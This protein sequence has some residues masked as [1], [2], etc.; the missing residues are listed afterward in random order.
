LR[1]LSEKKFG[2]SAIVSKG[3]GAGQIQKSVF[4]FSILDTYWFNPHP[5]IS[6]VKKVIRG[7]KFQLQKS[8][9]APPEEIKI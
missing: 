1:G 7:Q 9:V 4:E 3:K 2:F 6:S 5:I 8:F